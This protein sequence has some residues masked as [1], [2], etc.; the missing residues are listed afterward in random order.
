MS[1]FRQR[2]FFKLFSRSILCNKI[3]YQL[4]IQGGRNIIR[5]KENS[6]DSKIKSEESSGDFF[7]GEKNWA[8]NF[9]AT[10]LPV[11]KVSGEE[12]TA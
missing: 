7:P 1:L 8:K 5:A 12:L 10:N 6:I 2:I 9:S 3:L 4:L 11:E